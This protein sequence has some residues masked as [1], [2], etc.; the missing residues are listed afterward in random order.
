MRQSEK[1]IHDHLKQN[2]CEIISHGW[3]DFLVKKG[4][5]TYAVEVKT[6]NDGLQKHQ[7]EMHRTLK[8][9]GLGTFTVCDGAIT[10]AEV[11]A[12]TG[13]NRPIVINNIHV[14][15]HEPEPKPQPEQ[16]SLMGIEA[17]MAK[18]LI[19]KSAYW[20]EALPIA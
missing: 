2:G 11:P 13:K 18:L 10:H 20:L 16:P 8:E 12:T 7:E 5:E 14:V 3:P 1:E 17:M 6:P 4:S 19:A 15:I 9:L